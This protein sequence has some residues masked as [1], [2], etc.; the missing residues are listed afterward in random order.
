MRK[1]LTLIH[2]GYGAKRNAEYLL[3]YGTVDAAVLPQ[4]LLTKGIY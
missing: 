3:S 1:V 2:K 4:C